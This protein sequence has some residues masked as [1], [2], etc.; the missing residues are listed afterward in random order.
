MAVAWAARSDGATGWVITVDPSLLESPLNADSVEREMAKRK[1]KHFGRVHDKATEYVMIIDDVIPA[2][3]AL[4]RCNTLFKNL[5]A[6]NAAKKCTNPDV[7]HLVEW[8]Y[9]LILQDPT[10]GCVDWFTS[11]PESNT[12]Y[13]KQGVGV[14]YARRAHLL[15]LLCPS[16]SVLECAYWYRWAHKANSFGDSQTALVESFWA[17]YRLISD[18]YHSQVSRVLEGSHEGK[19][20]RCNIECSRPNYCSQRC[21]SEVC[22]SCQGPFTLLPGKPT[23]RIEHHEPNLERDIEISKLEYKLSLRPLVED[24]EALMAFRRSFCCRMA[25]LGVLSSSSCDQCLDKRVQL[26]EVHELQLEKQHWDDMIAAVKRLRAQ[27]D[28]QP[29]FH[30]PT[31]VCEP[32]SR[33]VL[34][35]SPLKRARHA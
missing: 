16:H 28:V 32:C 12:F 19:C 8:G 23:I 3:N 30:P 6:P 35:E 2:T 25:L 34:Y 22:L 27:P 10:Y 26:K 29:P 18:R 33:I 1:I 15:K 5:G 7:V 24:A 17:T 4:S 9:D 21:A 13:T 31:R 11:A 20:L 14:S